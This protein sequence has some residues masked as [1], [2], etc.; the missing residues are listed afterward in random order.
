MIT[1]PL[2]ANEAE[3]LNALHQ[4]DIL[5]TPPERNYDNLAKLA[6]QIWCRPMAVVSLIGADRQWLKAKVGLTTW[7]IPQS[8]LDRVL[9]E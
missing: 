6:S 8:V 5:D 3:R 4:Y 2:P 9:A 1:S 7:A